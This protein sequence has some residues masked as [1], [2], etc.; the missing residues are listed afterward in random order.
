MK[1][2]SVFGTRPE[3]IKMAPLVKELQ[4]RNIISSICVTAQHREMLDQVMELFEL[5]PDYDLNIMKSGQ[6]LYDITSSVI[7]RLKGVYS[8]FNPDLILV[9]GDTTTSMVAALAAYYKQIPVGHV[10]AGLRTHNIYNPWPEELNRRITSCIAKYNF[11]PTK[12]SMQNLINE[13]IPE[14][15]IF[16]TG[17][18]VIDA[19]FSILDKIKTDV[20]VLQTIYTN[21]KN[22]GFNMKFVENWEKGHRMVLITCHRRENFGKNMENIFEAIKELCF[23]FSHVSFVLPMHLNPNVRN[24][25]R[26]VFQNVQLNNLFLTEPLD[27]LSFTYLMKLSYLIM[28]DSGGIQEEAPSLGKLVLVLRETTER[29]EAIQAGTVRLVG[30][31]FNNIVS[32]VEKVLILESHY[33]VNK[34]PYGEGNSSEIIADIIINKI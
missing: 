32:E 7:M 20:S 1:V 28:T 5:M 8:E 4:K 25:I 9:H 10:E 15:S 26:N 16:I 18:T 29:P 2:L 14:N 33:L 34:N 11:T 12:L 19:L 13:S 23:R 31:D 30:T 22:N 17:N 3:A 21:L 24:I 27:Y 6:D